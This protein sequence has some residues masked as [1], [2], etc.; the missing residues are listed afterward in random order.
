MSRKCF[1]LFLIPAIYLS[2]CTSQ[3]DKEL[4]SRNTDEKV[5]EVLRGAIETAG[6]WNAW[7]RL[8]KIKFDKMTQLYDATGQTEVKTEQ[9][10]RYQLFPKHIL[11][12]IWQDS[13]GNHQLMLRHGKVEKYIN[14]RKDPQ[15]DSVSARNDLLASEYAVLLPFRLLDPDIHFSFEGTD[16]L[17]DETVYIVRAQYEPGKNG[18][19]Q[20]PDIW[21]HYFNTENY[22]HE[23]YCVKH[24]DHYSLVINDDFTRVDKFIFPNRRTSYR[25]DE[26]GRRLYKRA[27]YHYQNY[28]V[29]MED[30]RN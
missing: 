13:T 8:R 12:I 19:Q 5:R 14:G 11:E 9:H 23:G 17:S 10:H 21:W 16:T 29:R 26:S 25:V 22:T 20:E 6:G 24:K 3:T 27:D 7:N 4:F 18:S 28:Q 1:Y 2:G 15:V 30:H